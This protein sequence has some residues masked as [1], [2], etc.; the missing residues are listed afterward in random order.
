[1]Q[2]FFVWFWKTDADKGGGRKGTSGLVN[3]VLG[4]NLAVF[5]TR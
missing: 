5:L 4:F 2:L 3:T 1:M